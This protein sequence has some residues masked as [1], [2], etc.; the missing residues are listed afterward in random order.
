[1]R[2]Q[3]VERSSGEQQR[4]RCNRG[5]DR[6]ANAALYRIVQSGLRWDPRTHEYLKR[7]TSE[8]KTRREVISCFKRCVAREISVKFSVLRVA[9]ASSPRCITVWLRSGMVRP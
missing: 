9:A 6:Q 8:G 2:S 4:R 7:R 3:P 1:M 5:G